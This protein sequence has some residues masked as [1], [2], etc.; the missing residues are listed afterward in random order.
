[1]IVKAAQ[2]KPLTKSGLAR[3]QDVSISSLYYQPLKPQKDW[4][5]KNQIEQVLTQHPSYGHRRVAMELKINKKRALR[6]MRL[7]GLK[8]YRRRGRKY[9]KTKDKSADYPNLL[10]SLPFPKKSNQI[11]ASD[12][13]HLSF[14]GRWVYLATIVDLYHRQVVGWSLLTSHAGQLTMTALIDALEKSGRPTMLHSDH[15]SEYKSRAYV[16]F[17]ESLG[18]QI[19]M[20]QKGCPWQNGYQE[21]FY[22]Q[23]K[24]DLGDPNRFQTL[25]ELAAA[26][27]AQIYY[28]NHQ[29]IH[30][31]LKMPPAKFSQ[32]H[33]QLTTHP[34]SAIL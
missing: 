28:Y 17:A 21:S 23:F 1:M 2:E 32:R 33:D 5:L 15:G 22:S 34:L 30:T 13:T 16:N 24:V 19:S 4:H 29:R 26:V 8:P 25:G 20:S 31:K 7:F 6:V 27:Y 11:W 14:H 12:F 3:Q 10:P 9:R 18:I